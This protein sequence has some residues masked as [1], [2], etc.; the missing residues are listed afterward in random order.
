MLAQE[1]EEEEEELAAKKK[2]EEEGPGRHLLVT[3]AWCGSVRPG[4]GR[5]LYDREGLG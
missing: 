3:Q 5:V 1:E 2:E 4:R